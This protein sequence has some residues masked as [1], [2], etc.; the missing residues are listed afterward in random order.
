MLKE[1]N[2]NKNFGCHGLRRA[3]EDLDPR[4][5]VNREKRAG[6]SGKKVTGIIE[7]VVRAT[8]KGIHIRWETVCAKTFRLH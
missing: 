3:K 8:G 2:G 6:A 5:I 1:K 7:R 4:K